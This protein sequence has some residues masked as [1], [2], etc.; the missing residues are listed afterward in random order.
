M[1]VS[2][3]DVL[4]IG[5]GPA[6]LLAA[7]V[8]RQR[9]AKVRVLATGIGTT[10]VSPGWIGVLDT[11]GGLEDELAR[12]TRTHPQHPYALAG[13]DALHKGLAAL[14]EV[15]A[16]ARLN[17]VGDLDANLVL[18]TALGA[19]IRAAVVPESFAAGDLAAPGPMLIAGLAGWR[20]FYPKLCAD[21]LARQ[22]FPVRATTF[23]LPEMTAGKFDPT[24]AGLARLFD[25][26]DVRQRVAGQLKPRLDGATRV[27]LPAVLGLEHAA[28]AWRDLRDLLGLPVF[29]IPTLPPSVPGMRLFNAFNGALTRAGVQILLDM[30]VTRGIMER[31]RVAGVVVSN[32][33][34]EQTYRAGTVILATGGLYGG[35]ISTDRFG[36]MR[37]VVF[38]L[39]LYVPAFDEG[40]SYLAE[41]QR[42]TGQVRGHVG[43]WFAPQFLG[44]RE[45]PI[46]YVGVCAN[47]LM[48]P[49][50]ENARVVLEN[51]R[52]AGRLLAGYNPLV[53]GSTEG[54]WMATAYRAAQV[55]K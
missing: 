32:V 25:R 40:F 17:Y 30:T 22:G 15:C 10:H 21:N 48:Q 43:D 6:G 52:I 41:L 16:G 23:D 28:D 2:T 12:W 5:A 34:R 38:G 27:G 33:V 7:W 1:A 49:V 50:D 55:A 14:R 36:A 42:G 18:P 26:P 8:A 24:P 54:V 44:Q 11:E 47:S 19:T 20:D 53:E 29:E 3:D 45:H 37:E 4:V 9:G 13:G 46:H 39:P 31:G 35:G 51:V